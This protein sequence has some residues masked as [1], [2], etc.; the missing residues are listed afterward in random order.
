MADS[1]LSVLQ[2]NNVVEQRITISQESQ[3]T[4]QEQAATSGAP[5]PTTPATTPA[6]P[7]TPATTGCAIFL[8]Y[9]F[10]MAF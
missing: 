2:P 4:T 6:T 9:S 10:N 5:Q 1:A 7:A 8:D 3:Q